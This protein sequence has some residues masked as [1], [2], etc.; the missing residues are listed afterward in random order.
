MTRI[1]VQS[2][3][4][5]HAYHSP[6]SGTSDFQKCRFFFTALWHEALCAA[7]SSATFAYSVVANFVVRRG[8]RQDHNVRS[9]TDGVH[10]RKLRAGENYVHCTQN[11]PRD[12][13][14]NMA[15]ASSNMHRLKLSFVFF[16]TILQFWYPGKETY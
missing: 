12:Q 10:H 8:W 7:N 5:R 11:F 2:D 3:S 14:M 1:L 16:V 15:Q 4:T 9:L 6:C 13:T